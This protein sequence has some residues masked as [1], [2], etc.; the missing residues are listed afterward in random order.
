MQ[1]EKLLQQGIDCMEKKKKSSDEDEIF[2]Q[3]VATEL[4]SNENP[5]AKRHTKWQI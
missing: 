3:Y 2:G 4:C 1:E 5:Q